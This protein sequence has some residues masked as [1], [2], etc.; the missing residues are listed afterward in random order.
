MLLLPPLDRTSQGVFTILDRLQSRNA[1]TAFRTSVS[2]VKEREEPSIRTDRSNRDYPLALGAVGHWIKPA[3]RFISSLMGRYR[4]GSSLAN[5]CCALFCRLNTYMALSALGW[6]GSGARFAPEVAC[7]CSRR[8]DRRGTCLR[9]LRLGWHRRLRL[10]QG[11]RD[12]T[13]VPARYAPPAAGRRGHP[14]AR[15]SS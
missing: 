12:R 9:A 6:P 4:G 14:R 10:L 7:R 2:K 15:P 8:S 13:P 11:R 3:W 1:R 5:T